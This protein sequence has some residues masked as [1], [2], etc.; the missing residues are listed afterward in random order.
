MKTQQ[1]TESVSITIP[2]ECIEPLKRAAELSGLSIEEEAKEALLEHFNGFQIGVPARQLMPFLEAVAEA[3][4][5][6][7]SLPEMVGTASIEPKA[8]VQAIA[9]A[10]VNDVSVSDEQKDRVGALAL[11]ALIQLDYP[12][13]IRRD[14]KEAEDCL[15]PL[16]IG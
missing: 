10:V 11:R 7:G 2:A 13:W 4:G 3:V 8:F 6:E 1:T 15:G 5:H 12:G 16:M 9:T 14:R